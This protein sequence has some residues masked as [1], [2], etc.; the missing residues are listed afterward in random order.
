MSRLFTTW[1]LVVLSWLLI[2]QQV[3]MTSDRL[4]PV[5]VMP[6]VPFPFIPPRQCGNV[7]ALERVEI[8][9][10][11]GVVEHE[12]I[13]TFNGYFTTTARK[14]FIQ[15]ALREAEVPSWQIVPRNNPAS[16]YPSDFEVVLLRERAQAGRDALEDHPNVKRVTPQRRVRRTLKRI[17]YTTELPDEN[18]EPCADK[19]TPCWAQTW[20]SSRPLKRTSLAYSRKKVLDPVL[21]RSKGQARRKI[22]LRPLPELIKPKAKTKRTV[23]KGSKNKVTVKK[24][25]AFWHS[26]GR[27]TSRRLLR[28]VPRQVTH[29]LQADLLW[30]MGFAGSG[31]KVAVFDTGL[32]ENHPHFRNLKD[33]TNWTNEKT[34]NDGLGHGTFVAGV[35]ASSKECQGFSPDADLHIFRVFTNNQVSYTS[36][37]LDA[38]NY[39]ILKKINVLNLS[40]GGPDFMDHPFVD[41]VWELTANKVIMVSAIGNDGPLYGTLNNPADQMDV[42]GVGGIDF[43]DKIARFSSRGMTTWELPGGYGRVKPDIVTYGSGV[44]GSGLK[45]G[46]RTLSGTSVASP[47]VAGAVTLLASAVIHRIPMVNPA[48]MKQALM[49]SARRL[50]GVNMFEQGHGKLDL[51]KAYQVLNSY[52]PQAS[53]SPSYI[54]LTDCP[55]MWPYCTQPIYYGGMPTIV[56]VTILNGMGVTGRIVDKPIWQPYTPQNG[57]Y[58]EVAFSYSNVLWPWSGYLAVSITAA[59]KAAKWDG[60]AQGQVTLTVSSPPE[61][62]E[63]EERTSTVKLPVRVKVVPTPPRSKRVLWDQ[64]H[65]LRYPPGY[66]PRDNLRMKNDPLDWNG[67]HPHTNFKDTYQHLRNAGYYVEIL[68]APLTCFDAN[69]YGTL[70]IVDSEEEFFPEE[71]SK[72]K[73]DIDNGLSVIVIADWYN[74]SVMKK[75]KF[76]DENTR[77]WWMPDTGGANVPALNDLMYPW[78][79]AFSD[80]VY[81]GDFTLGDHD[82]YYASGSSIA[83]FPEDGIMIT[84]TLKDQ[85]NEVLKQES[86]TVD[87]VPILGLYQMTG[88]EAGRVALYGDSNCLDNSHLQKDCFWLLDALLQY[89]SHNHM[90]P[91]FEQQGSPLSIMNVELPERMEGNHLARYSKVLESS[92][93]GQ[94]RP[95][96]ACPHLSWAKGEPLNKS[97]PSNLYM[98]Q[99]LLSIDLMEPPVPNV[100]RRQPGIQHIVSDGVGWDIQPGVPSHPH[101]SIQSMPVFALAGLTLVVV[102]F[103][104]HIHKSRSKPKRRKPR[105]KRPTFINIVKPVV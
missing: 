65:N 86:Q 78:N 8:G 40:I 48:S 62:G 70:L 13:V 72:L 29:V 55:Y 2:G 104:V 43:E 28:T 105:L 68:G 84:Q 34:L 39:A 25:S 81:E 23:G 82:M 41:K 53:L 7:T 27:H 16:D 79:M 91:V 24:G 37:F 15:A 76:Y 60:I 56:N 97:A 96:P 77:Q 22:P 5:T 38:F 102:F 83:K 10:K 92:L 50:P 57:D 33:R 20:Q 11:T 6:E 42:I 45:S 47:V 3:Q 1:R 88:E 19:G 103:A 95:L 17:E 46:C 71:I 30:A 21:H 67:D 75:V 35:I 61:E 98:H 44:R 73:R 58:I 66:F 12:Y 63:K 14:N 101:N 80:Q 4:V 9:F 59:K 100:V 36:W 52:K 49:A 99:K 31:I 93:A 87:T 51:L 89:T 94:T 64:Y 54:D 18:L 90:P 69:Q 26:T 74:V 85:G 32:S